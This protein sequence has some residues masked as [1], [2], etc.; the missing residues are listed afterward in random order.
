MR[1]TLSLDGDLMREVKRRAAE[2]DQTVSA[3]VETAL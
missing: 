1:T 2:T 3:M